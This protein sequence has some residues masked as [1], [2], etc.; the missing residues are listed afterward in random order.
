MKKS[1]KEPRLKEFYNV[2][3][4]FAREIFPDLHAP[5]LGPPSI[6]SVLFPS[7]MKQF[8]LRDN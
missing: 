4:L 5:G 8:W 6:N 1:G 2:T 7:Q 3:P